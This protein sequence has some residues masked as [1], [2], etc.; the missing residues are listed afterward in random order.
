MGDEA[1]DG[2]KGPVAG[3]TVSVVEKRLRAAKKKLTRIVELESSGKQLTDEQASP[4]GL[5]HTRA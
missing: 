3:G 4:K 1:G 5:Q 2:P